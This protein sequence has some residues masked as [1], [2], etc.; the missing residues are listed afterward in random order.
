MKVFKTVSCHIETDSSCKYVSH[1][2]AIVSSVWPFDWFEQL[3]LEMVIDYI[4][5]KL[6]SVARPTKCNWK[7][8]L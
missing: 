2:I 7:L 5:I 6:T 1:E 8:E 4:C 3:T